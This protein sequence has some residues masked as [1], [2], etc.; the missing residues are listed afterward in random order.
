MAGATDSATARR[1]R[2]QITRLTRGGRV[3]GN[4]HGGSSGGDSGAEATLGAVGTIISKFN[5]KVI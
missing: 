5:T 2:Y 4:Y 1:R 3:G